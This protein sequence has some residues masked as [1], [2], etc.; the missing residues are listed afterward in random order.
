MKNNRMKGR[1]SAL[2][3]GVAATA[4][5]VVLAVFAVELTRI[6]SQDRHDTQMRFRQRAQIAS[7]L[8]DA[9]LSSVASPS[10]QAQAIQR[11]GG[12]V[13]DATMRQAAR[14]GHLT[15]AVLVDPSGRVLA[16]SNRGVA[17]AVSPLV[18][19]GVGRAV[20]GGRPY[21][22]SGILPAGPHGAPVIEL[23]QPVP[24]P[25][26]KRV[27]ISAFPMAAL[28]DFLHAY[29]AR[30]S[31]GARTRAYVLDARGNVIGGAGPGVIPGGPVPDRG[32]LAALTRGPE[33]GFAGDRYRVSDRVADASWR[34]VLTAPQGVLFAS[35]TGAGKWV[36][37]L[38]FAAFAGLGVVALALL[39][40]VLVNAA[41]ELWTANNR[42][43]EA[44]RRLAL[45][46]DDLEE[47]AAEL[48]R[49]N[50]ELDQFA[51]IAS[52]DLQ[53]PLR[54]VQTFA[55]QLATRETE[56]LSPKGQDYLRRMGAAA[57]RMQV[58]IED[59]L[60]FSRVSTHGQDFVEV[61]LNEVA[62]EVLDDLEVSVREAGATVHVDELPTLRADPLQM[63]QL[64]QNLISNA[65]KFRRPEVPLEISV[66]GR[67]TRRFAELVVADNGIGFEPQ[68]GG[69]IFLVFERLHGAGTYPGTGIGLALCRKIVTRHGGQISAEA[70]PGAGAAF[71]VRLPR[72]ARLTADREEHAPPAPEEAPLVRS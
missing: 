63:R 39:R 35:Q 32:L 16:A 57:A 30:V 15:F 42:L 24:T 52:H 10:S 59:L 53:E 7:A 71:T 6:Q 55:G 22:L 37:W 11:Y 44:N 14:Q 65:L 23:A 3:L 47:R 54:K 20:L 12:A 56:R 61:D 38:I 5:L 69:R 25:A 34:V 9:L 18:A 58:L 29:L 28:G 67:N 17:S 62:R 26:G 21:S 36:P 27:L 1:S 49:S 48:A 40:G 4:L 66:S 46:N 43:Q 19:G 45:V 70:R 60:K 41:G 8:T 64:L 13:S 31:S 50:A 33:G 51:S 2:V 72:R 68:Y